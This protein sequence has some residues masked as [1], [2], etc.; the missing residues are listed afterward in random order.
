M[1]DKLFTATKAVIENPSGKILLLKES[2]KYDEGTNSGKWDVAGG[3]VKKRRKIHR[4]P[5]KRDRRG[6]R[7]ESGGQ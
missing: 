3:R 6:N 1:V 2:K 5:E 4:R 7:P